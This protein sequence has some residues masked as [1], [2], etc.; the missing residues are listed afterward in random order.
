MSNRRE[1]GTLACRDD[2]PRLTDG[3]DALSGFT[4]ILQLIDVPCAFADEHGV[5]VWVNDAFVAAFGNVRGRSIAEMVSAESRLEVKRLLAHRADG[6]Q[7]TEYVVD[8]LLGHGRRVRTEASWVRIDSSLFGAAVF[9]VS[10][11]VSRVTAAQSGLQLTPRQAEV[12]QLLAAG[13]TTSQIADE[14]H[15]SIHT[16][17]NHIRQLLQSLRVHSRLEAVAKARREGL[18]AD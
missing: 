8:A 15:V 5:Y 17:R 18:I 3:F 10:I 2:D 7:V 11:P 12:L 6:G 14:L 4:A 16:V 1:D 13:A 9:G